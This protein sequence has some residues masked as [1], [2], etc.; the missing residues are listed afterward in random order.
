MGTLFALRFL[1]A[2]GACLSR[3]AMWLKHV[4]STSRLQRLLATFP[5]KKKPSL[6]T[7]GPSQHHGTVRLS[8]QQLSSGTRLPDRS[9]WLRPS[10]RRHGPPRGC[11]ACY[12]G[13]PGARAAAFP[14][15]PVCCQ[16]TVLSY[17]LGC[18][19]RVLSL[20]Q[21]GGS[22]IQKLRE[23]Q[24]KTFQSSWGFCGPR[25]A[26]FQ[27]DFRKDCFGILSVNCTVLPDFF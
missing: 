23:G 19:S 15:H 24:H 12:L 1:G 2:G 8:A 13:G 3:V 18:H 26:V 10:G 11:T 9:L 5:V 4:F 20:S 21:I 27:T 14:A 7:E 17:G 25:N 22:H 16:L 6:L